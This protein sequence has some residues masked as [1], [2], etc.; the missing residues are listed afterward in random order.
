MTKYLTTHITNSKGYNSVDKKPNHMNNLLG[1]A[2]LDV[3]NVYNVSLQSITNRP[4][5]QQTDQPTE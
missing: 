1:T 5:K 2:M 3:G 4:T